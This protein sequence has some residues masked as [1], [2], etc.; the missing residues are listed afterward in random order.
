MEITS[1]TFLKVVVYVYVLCQAAFGLNS[2]YLISATALSDSSVSLSWRNNDAATVGY[3]IQRRDSTETVYHFVD[4]VKSATQL[5]YTDL[6]NLRSVTLY[7]YQ[8]IAYDATVLSDTSNSMQVTTLALTEIFKAPTISISSWHGET[9]TSVQISIT[10]SSNCEIG[11]RIYRE[12]D[13]S[14]SFSVIADTVSSIPKRRGD[15]IVRIDNT[16]SFNTWYRY[17]VAAYKSND[18]LFSAPCTTFTFHYTPQLPQNIVRFQKL[19]DYPVSVDSNGWSARAGDSIIL[20]ET[21]APAGTPFTV[22][23]V[24]NPASPVF[25]GYIDSAAARAYPL[26]TLIPVFLNYGVSNSY[27]NTK[28]ISYSDRMLITKDST[29]RMYQVAGSNLVSIDSVTIPQVVANLLLLNDTFLIIQSTIYGNNPRNIS[30][31]AAY[32]SSTGF[33]PRLF[34]YVQTINSY[35]FGMTTRDLRYWRPNIQG[36]VDQNMYVSCDYYRYERYTTSI[37][38]TYSISCRIYN[39]SNNA[40]VNTPVNMPQANVFNTGH[41]LSPNENLCTNG[42]PFLFFASPSSETLDH[43]FHPGDVA[44]E[45]FVVSDP[46]DPRPHMTDSLNNAIYRDTVHKQN[47]LQNILLDTANQRVFLVFTNNLSVLGYQ[48]VS[49]SGIAERT[50][51]PVTAKGNIT[52]LPGPVSSSVSIVLPGNSRTADL[53]FYDLSGRVVDQMQGVTSNAVLWRPAVKTMGCY[54]VMVKSGQEKFTAKF[55]VR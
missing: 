4:S 19:S 27:T 54:I 17:R 26:Q 45:L 31:Y 20:R 16:V 40:N 49:A 51:K 44:T 29:I 8:V 11:Y 46:K 14:S 25:A 52:V 6:K 53:C 37:F 13:F 5:T 15:V 50:M 38:R 22:I 23:N 9:S 24:S 35:Y 55:M 18:S 36:V 28:V 30:F 43:S 42:F 48:R 1:K 2:P 41:Y 47:T 34:E 32:L 39:L 10:D 12:Q 21:N 33:S 3:L 7:T